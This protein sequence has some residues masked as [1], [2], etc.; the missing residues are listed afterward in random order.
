MDLKT[1][2][3]IVIGSGATG[4]MAALTLAEQGIRVLIIEAGPNLTRTE[5]VN[6]E[7]NSTFQ[8][9]SKIISGKSKNQNQHPGYWKR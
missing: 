4:G 6:N 7:P 1:Y 2:E 5:V 9:L 8:R 3:A